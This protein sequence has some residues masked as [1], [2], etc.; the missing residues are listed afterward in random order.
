LDFVPSFFD[1]IGI[2]NIP[3]LQA[4]DFS[5]RRPTTGTG[6]HDGKIAIWGDKKTHLGAF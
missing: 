6:K 3:I 2:D 5:R 1:L 4:Y